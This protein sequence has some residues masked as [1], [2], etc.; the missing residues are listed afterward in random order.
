MRDS[1]GCGDRRPELSHGGESDGSAHEA[2]PN[3]AHGA[4][5]LHHQITRTAN[6][7]T[8]TSGNWWA[9]M[10]FLMTGSMVLVSALLPSNALTI[11]GNPAWPG[12]GPCPAHAA[13]SPS[14]HASSP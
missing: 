9:A 1:A 6:T 14:R 7:T 5:P 13:N 11:S 4:L 10:N 12:R 8:V 3:R 2:L